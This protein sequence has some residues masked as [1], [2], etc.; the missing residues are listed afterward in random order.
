MNLKT[1]HQESARKR[2]WDQDRATGRSPLSTCKYFTTGTRL[3]IDDLG[4]QP[5]RLALGD[6]SRFELTLFEGLNT[7]S[8]SRISSIPLAKAI[9][10]DMTLS[11]KS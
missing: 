2:L 6:Q 3:M 8:G 10:T 11:E 7:S 1:A 9:V 4:S 5:V